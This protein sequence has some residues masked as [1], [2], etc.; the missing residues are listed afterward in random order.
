MP[1]HRRHRLARLV[2]EKIRRAP[3]KGEVQAP[4][5]HIHNIFRTIVDDRLDHRYRCWIQWC[6]R[7]AQ[8]ADRRFDFRN[9]ADGDIL[10]LQHVER[11][12]D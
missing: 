1:I 4:P 10:F 9:Q 8:F 5:G 3:V 2:A 12:A 7:P 6:L 11:L